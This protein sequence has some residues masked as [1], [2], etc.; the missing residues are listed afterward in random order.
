LKEWQPDQVSLL[1]EPIEDAFKSWYVIRDDQAAQDFL[2][3]MPPT[4]E[5]KQAD[6]GASPKQ[7]PRP[8]LADLHE[9]DL[10]CFHTGVH[11]IPGF[12]ADRLPDALRDLQLHRSRRGT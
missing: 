3:S 11:K 9:R 10:S 1:V 4:R 2:I 12:D 8:T 7:K 6:R 5:K